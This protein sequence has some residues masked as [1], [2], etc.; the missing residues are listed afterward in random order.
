MPCNFKNVVS[1]AANCKE[2]PAGLSSYCMV[3]PLDSE[4][5]TKIGVHDGANR[6]IITPPATATA[7]TGFRIDFKPQTG[8][9]T[10]EDNGDGNGWS[11]TGTG[12]VDRNEDDMAYLSRVMHNAG[13]KYLVFFP[14]GVVTSEGAEWKVVGNQFGDCTW[15]T[16]ADSG[17]NRNDDHGQT[18]T[19]TCPY[20][21]Y[22]V[23]KWY[24]TINQASDP[25]SSELSDDV[26]DDVTVGENF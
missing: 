8:Q 4:Y 9:V 6:Y 1:G 2:N 17:A 19:V 11:H 16:V 18:F 21:L 10:S 22:P 24:G 3:V 25:S 14:A 5:L 23:M 26:S 15:Q 12:R 20:Q 13:G 7:L